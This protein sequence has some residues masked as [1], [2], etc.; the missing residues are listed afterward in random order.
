MSAVV[1]R[2]VKRGSEEST[3]VTGPELGSREET[4]KRTRRVS[5]DEPDVC[6]PRG[7]GQ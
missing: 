6:K 4:A 2:G 3:T 5:E 1:Q 7:K